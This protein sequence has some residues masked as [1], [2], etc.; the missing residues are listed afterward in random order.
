MIQMLPGKHGADIYC[1]IMHIR[2]DYPLVKYE[3]LPYTWGIQKTPNG[4][5]AMP[6]AAASWSLVT[7]VR[8]SIATLSS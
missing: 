1:T 4:S 2:L 3:A 5:S 7:S 6:K 8:V